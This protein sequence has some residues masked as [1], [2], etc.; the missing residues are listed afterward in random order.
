MIVRIVLALLAFLPVSSLFAQLSP[1][2]HAHP[3]VGTA[4]EG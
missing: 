4:N 1:V 3:L 2:D